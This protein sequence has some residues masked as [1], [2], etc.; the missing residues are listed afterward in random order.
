MELV[1]V[2]L[3]KTFIDLQTKEN[4]EF[5]D[6][7]ISVSLANYGSIMKMLNALKN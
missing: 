3:I 7:V 6:K 4:K 2:R 5:N 1:K